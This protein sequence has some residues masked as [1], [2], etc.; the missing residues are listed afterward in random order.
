MDAAARAMC[1]WDGIWDQYRHRDT[2]AGWLLT[3]GGEAAV[4]M[5]SALED[6]PDSAVHFRALL[7]QQALAPQIRAVITKA[8]RTPRE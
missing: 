4:I 5:L 1:V 2:I 7:D 6:Y 3:L 8:A